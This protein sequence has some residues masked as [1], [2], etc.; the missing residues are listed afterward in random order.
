[1]FLFLALLESLCAIFQAIWGDEGPTALHFYHLSTLMFRPDVRLSLTTILILLYALLADRPAGRISKHWE[2]YQGI[3]QAWDAG[4]LCWAGNGSRRKNCFCPTPWFNLWTYQIF[5]HNYFVT[6]NR[7]N[8]SFAFK[9]I[10][11]KK[12]EKL[13]TQKYFLLNLKSN[14]DRDISFKK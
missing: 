5:L 10:L 9:I 8:S 13:H 11:S 7:Y 2:V 14:W 6:I 4:G 1:M 12:V 3:I